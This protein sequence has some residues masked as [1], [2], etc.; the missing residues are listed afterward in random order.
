MMDMM[1]AITEQ[2][3]A[4]TDKNREVVDSFDEVNCCV[5]E[6]AL[7]DTM[8]RIE[9]FFRLLLDRMIMQLV[10]YSYVETK[11]YYPEDYSSLLLFLYLILCIFMLKAMQLY[12]HII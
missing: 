11:I 5:H 4:I 9:C 6:C 2:Q 8:I 3:R 10:N 1:A 12:K 7:T